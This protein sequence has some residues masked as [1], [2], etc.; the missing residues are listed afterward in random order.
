MG[1]VVGVI[2]GVGVLVEGLVVDYE[3]FGFYFYD[4]DYLGFYSITG[5]GFF[6][7]Y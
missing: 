2:V 4:F 5:T 7:F 6:F 1:V 3:L